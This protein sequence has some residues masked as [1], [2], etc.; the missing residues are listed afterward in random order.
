MCTNSTDISV[1]NENCA[2]NHGIYCGFS[3]AYTTF[4]L[5]FVVCSTEKREN[6]QK[7]DAN[8]NKSR[9]FLLVLFELGMNGKI[10]THLMRT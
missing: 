5:A 4:P 7:Q 6:K 8:C 2:R 3:F 9:V 1:S 10:L